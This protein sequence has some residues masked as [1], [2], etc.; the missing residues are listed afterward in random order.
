[1]RISEILEGI[2]LPER[3]P[4]GSKY[5]YGVSSVN[6]FDDC[7]DPTDPSCPGHRVGLNW[8]RLHP[9]QPVK[10]STNPSVKNGIDQYD[11]AIRAG[12]KPIAPTIMRKGRFVGYKNKPAQPP[13]PPKPFV[14]R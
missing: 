8:R 6:Q 4:N 10:P 1:M 5:R 3:A 2:A 7:V 11:N 14:D 9:N 12:H 13:Q